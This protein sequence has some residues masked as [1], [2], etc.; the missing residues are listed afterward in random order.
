MAERPVSRRIL[1]ASD[2][3]REQVVAA[4]RRH[5]EQGRLEVEELAERIGRALE[6]RT[7]GDLDDLLFDL[8]DERQSPAAARAPR[9]LWRSAALL[10]NLAQLAVVNLVCV[11]VWAL[12]GGGSFWPTW[13]MLA[14]LIV[15]A[16]RF[17]RLIEREERRRAL[18]DAPPPQP[19]GK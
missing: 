1:R 17:R 18:A 14:T 3:E 9:P 2:A 4:L 19:L 5:G 11:G 10:A 6:A 13:I 8:P 15:F 7:L 16:R 12:E